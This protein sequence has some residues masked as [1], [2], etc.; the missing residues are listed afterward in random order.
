MSQIDPEETQTIFRP[1]HK[2]RRALPRVTLGCPGKVILSG[3]DVVNVM[4]HDLSR[5]GLQIRCGKKAAH[6]INPAGKAIKDGAAPPEIQVLFYVPV[7]SGKGRVKAKGKLMYFSLI[8]P[9]IVA[10]GL[11]FKSISSGGVEH[12]RSVVKA[13][14]ESC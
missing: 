10:L 4:I 5:D 1:V 8:A 14:L 2:D 13:A 3:G 11:K 6:A 12:L 9:D 7:D